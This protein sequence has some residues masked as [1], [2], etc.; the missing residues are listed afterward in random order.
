MWAH[1]CVCAICVTC[2]RLPDLLDAAWGVAM[3]P[4]LRTGA[5]CLMP[6]WF[7]NDVDFFFGSFCGRMVVSFTRVYRVGGLFGFVSFARLLAVVL[8]WVDRC[9]D[10]WAFLGLF[11]LLRV[12]PGGH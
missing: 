11:C 7:W 8:C 12:T 3:C 9:F 2:V 6:A 1:P 10:S 5:L 4:P